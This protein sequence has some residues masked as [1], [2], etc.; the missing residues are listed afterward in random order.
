M[1]NLWRVYIDDS[2]DGKKQ[3]HV[4]AGALIGRKAGWHLFDKNWRKALKKRPRLEYFHQKE[5]SAS[6][7]E[8]FQ[9]RNQV[10]WPRPKGR[11]AMSAK[12][13]LL[14]GILLDASIVALGVTVTIPDYERVKQTHPRAKY[15]MS[16]DAFDWALQSVIFECAKAVKRVESD[17]RIA[18]VSDNSTSAARYTDIYTSFKRRNPIIAKSML[19]IAHLDDKDW[20]GLQAADMIAS[21]TKQIV[22]HYNEDG[23]ITAEVPLFDKFYTVGNVTEEYLLAVLNNQ[24]ISDEE[25]EGYHAMN[26][27]N[28]EKRKFD[29]AMNKL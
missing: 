6:D 24:T 26:A 10:L 2:A 8:F 18:F 1:S 11:E 7:G 21:T 12:R 14:R 3:S 22:D 19:G 16:R 28:D 9:F 29:D 23:S 4:V 27:T 17:A 25:L 13:D 20:P 15:F 5:Y